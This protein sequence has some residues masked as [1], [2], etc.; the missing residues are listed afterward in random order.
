MHEHGVAIQQFR[1]FENKQDVYTLEFF[2]KFKSL[3]F[4]CLNDKL[5]NLV[6]FL[7]FTEVPEY[8]VKA[9]IKAGGRGKGHFDNG[10]KGGVHLAKE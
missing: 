3:L 1:V 9:Q 4:L 7:Q 5:N 2:S 6:Y 10:F 8:V